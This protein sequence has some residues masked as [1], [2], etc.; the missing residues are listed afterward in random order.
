MRRFHLRTGGKT[1]NRVDG[2]PFVLPSGYVQPQG[3][4]ILISGGGDSFSPF[5]SI[6]PFF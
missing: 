2:S 1:D 5:W 6:A 3:A 4:A